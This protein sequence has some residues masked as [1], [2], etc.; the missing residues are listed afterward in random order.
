VRIRADSALELSSVKNS[1][2]ALNQEATHL[3]QNL[4]KLMEKANISH[5]GLESGQ[6]RKDDCIKAAREG[7]ERKQERESFG[8]EEIVSEEEDSARLWSDCVEDQML[9]DSVVAK[10]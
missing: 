5:L 3:Q 8:R 10:T 7:F 9:T 4:R 2:C 1:L 6:K